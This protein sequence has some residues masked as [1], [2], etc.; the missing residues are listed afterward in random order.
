MLKG[1]INDNQVEEIITFWNDIC[2]EDLSLGLLYLSKYPS[3]LAKIQKKSKRI[4]KLELELSSKLLKLYVLGYQ[5]LKFKDHNCEWILG[6]ICSI[7]TP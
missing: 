3:L 5:V 4:D 7:F 1:E 2:D 6:A